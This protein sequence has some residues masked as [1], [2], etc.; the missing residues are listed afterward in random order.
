VSRSALPSPRPRWQTAE[1]RRRNTEA[2]H[3]AIRENRAI[4]E[5]WRE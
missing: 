5:T 4:I 3:W 1:R 2:V